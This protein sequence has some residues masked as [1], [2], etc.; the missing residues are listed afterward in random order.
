MDTMREI[1]N[2]GRPTF[3]AWLS[4]PSSVNAEVAAQVG[5]DYVC[6]DNQHGALDYQVTVSMIQAIELGGG[7]PIVRVPWNEPGIIGKVLDAG[8]QGVIVPMVN[9]AEEAA[10]VVRSACY[11]PIGARSFGPMM[12]GGRVRNY[13]SMANDIVAVVP[14]VETVEALRNLD[15]I[16]ATPG[17]SAVYVGPA[18]LSFSLGLPPQNNDDRS[19]FTEALLRITSACRNAGVV[20]GIHASGALAERRLEQGFRMITVSADVLS[21]R[22]GMAEELAQSRGAATGPKATNAV[23]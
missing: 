23:Y 1:W 12:V 18:D 10:S 6:C 21:M 15:E 3:G 7:N 4:S 16:L 17:I 14:M 19:E 11:P 8:A 2:Q 13:A 5:F 22:R 20:P 9:T